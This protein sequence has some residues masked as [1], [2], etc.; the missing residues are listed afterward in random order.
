VVSAAALAGI[1]VA[2]IHPFGVAR[3]EVDAPSHLVVSEIVTGGPSASDE[4][5]EIHNPTAAPLPL[6]GL[7]VI[8]VSASGATISRRAAWGLEA[9]IVPAHGHLLIANEAGI[10]APIADAVYASGMASTGGSVAVRIQGAVTSIDAVGWGTSTSTWREGVAAPA[11]DAGSSIERL[12]GG[13]LGSVADTDDNAS[14]FVVRGLPEPQN[15][16]SPPTPSGGPVATPAPTPLPTIPVDTPAPTPG[17]SATAIADARALPDGATTT[18]EGVALAA[19]DFHDG[20]GFVADASGGIAVIVID[21]SFVRGALLRLSGELDDRFAQRT[22]RVAGF[23]VTPIGAGS[24]PAPLAATTGGVGEALEGRLV[25]VDGVVAGAPTV[26]TSG[27]AFD[28][29]DG[30]GATRIVVGSATGIDTSAWA[31]GSAIDL[32][33]VVGQRDSSGEGTAGYRVMPRDAEDIVSVAPPATPVPGSAGASPTAGASASA[34]PAG[35]STI[36]AARS[37]AKNARLTVRGVV[38]LP[39]GVVDKQTATIQDASGAIVLRLGDDVGRLVLGERIEVHGTR[40]TKSGMETLRVTEPAIHLGSAA[41]PA[42]GVLRTGDAGET[43]EAELV[44][45]RGALAAAAR[46]SSTGSVTFDIDDG[47]GPLKVAIGASLGFDPAPYQAGTWVQVTGVLGQVTTG[48]QP[49][50]GYR[51]WPRAAGEVRIVAGATGAGAAGATGATG[52]EPALAASLESVDGP[53]LGELTIGATL[54]AGPWPEL[55]I[56]GLLWDGTRLVGIDPASAGLVS[57]LLGES[58]PPLALQ[59]SGLSATGRLGS[60]GIPLVRL[61]SGA[62]EVLA[63]GTPPAGP[64]RLAQGRPPAW[65]AAVGRIG[66]SGSELTVRLA[67]TNVRVDRRCA[68]DEPRVPKGVV[69]VTGIAIGTPTRLIL[70]CGAIVPAPVA[71]GRVAVVPTAVSSSAA[72]ASEAEDAGVRRALAAGLLGLAAVGLGC[73]AAIRLRR[74][75]TGSRA[76]EPAILGREPDGQARGPRLALVRLPNEPGP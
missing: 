66:G 11:P 56:G 18:I 3:G 34:D 32:V 41:A 7:E 49:D 54:V 55:R 1:L 62:G 44:T 76:P 42:A 57:A 37:A 9:G 8:Y 47:S 73:L 2:A 58:R 23:D 51:V 4:L 74:S 38:T 35:V 25:H 63:A 13:P 69:G 28:L 22:L 48:S 21:G 36:G 71:N 14:D 43:R 67:G 60:L 30:S 65:V 10:Y 27:L 19:S 16:G 45:V 26:L 53:G 12:P 40:S 52:A 59:L 68:T 39:P 6:D 46:R 50:R 17:P 5:I 70:P 20:G 15:L 31:T 33:G 75:R 29:D 61:G 64:A 24:D 72:P